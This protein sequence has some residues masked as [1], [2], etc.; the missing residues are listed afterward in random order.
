V[1]A[2]LPFEQK[3]KRQEKTGAEPGDHYAQV[4]SS[5]KHGGSLYT[6]IQRQNVMRFEVRVYRQRTG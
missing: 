6:S 5:F 4:E 3:Y 2:V 1:P